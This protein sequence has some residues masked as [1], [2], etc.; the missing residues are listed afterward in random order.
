MVDKSLAFD[1]GRVLHE[2]IG[3]L[4]REP[5]PRIFTST[6][7]MYLRPSSTSGSASGRNSPRFHKLD[8]DLSSDDIELKIIYSHNA[9]GKLRLRSVSNVYEEADSPSKEHSINISQPALRSPADSRFIFR[10]RRL[11][12]A[13]LP[14][15]PS[16][17]DAPPLPSFNGRP[18]SLGSVGK[19]WSSDSVESDV[20]MPDTPDRVFSSLFNWS[21]EVQN[22]G[23]VFLMKWLID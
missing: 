13:L 4:G 15:T 19:H 6:A 8:S 17:S 5:E 22:V 21:D 16:A 18:P 1:R 3:K 2:H 20:F 10:C 23:S 12:P 7:V 9:E 14:K 11:N